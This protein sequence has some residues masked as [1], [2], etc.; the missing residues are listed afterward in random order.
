MQTEEYISND[1]APL[2]LSD[3]LTDAKTLFDSVNFTHLPVIDNNKFVGL[4]AKADLFD[5]ENKKTLK[6]IQFSL[7]SFYTL[8]DTNWLDLF[9]IFSLNDTNLIPIIDSETNYLGYYELSDILHFL[10]STPFLKEDGSIIIIS[11]HPTEYSISEISQI[12]ESNDAKLQG[13]F[14]SEINDST[15]FITLKLHSNNINDVIHTFRRYEYNIVLGIKEDEYL[16][17][18]KNRSAYLTKYMSI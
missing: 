9:K 13:L 16:D 10:S 2:E 15:I 11:K 18:L 3:T 8:Q 14:I 5:F 17:D 6:D 12:V 7:H 4:L 1:I